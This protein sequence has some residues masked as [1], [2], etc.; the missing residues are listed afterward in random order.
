MLLTSASWIQQ[1]LSLPPDSAVS[2]LTGVTYTKADMPMPSSGVT[3][4]GE[5]RKA[6]VSIAGSAF[7]NAADNLSKS[8]SAAF[9]DISF[10]TPGIYT[11]KLA[12]TAG[13]V[14]GITYDGTVRYINVYV[15]N[16]VDADG[17][18]TLN[19][20]GTPWVAVSGITVWKGTN[21]LGTV[22][23]DASAKDSV[24]DSG[25]VTAS[26][27]NTFGNT[28]NSR[29]EVSKT[30]KGAAGNTNE[31]FS[32][33]FTTSNT[34][35]LA[36]QVFKGSAAVTETG[37]SGTIA[38]NGT[39]T[40]KNGETV[41]IYGL[42]ANDTYTIT[43]QNAADYKTSIAGSSGST[44]VISA[45]EDSKTAGVQTYSLTKA[46]TQAFTNSKGIT[47]PTGI[48]MDVLPFV[49]LVIF[50]GLQ[51]CICLSETA[52]KDKDKKSGLVSG[53]GGHG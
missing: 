19:A 45:A 51:P 10:T 21:Q 24:T 26:F 29:L 6:T 48:A 43:E 52:G 16:V 42:S 3:G 44:D 4:T 27:M 40:L 20:D 22:T 35:T 30:V 31:Q 47:P 46:D 25:T 18:V 33:L 11:Y 34:S 7:T 17:N 37:K 15:D 13:T 1:A 12:E 28:A 36:Y 23:G 41:H 39:F 2:S 14:P 38:N 53:R 50:A 5:T 8:G 49:I 32:F 9:G